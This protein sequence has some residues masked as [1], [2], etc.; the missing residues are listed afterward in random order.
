MGRSIG[1]DYRTSAVPSTALCFVLD[2]MVHSHH[3]LLCRHC[4]SGYSTI[5]PRLV[6]PTTYTVRRLEAYI[7]HVST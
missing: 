6:Y 2:S 5:L 1:W 7:I 3:I 4:R